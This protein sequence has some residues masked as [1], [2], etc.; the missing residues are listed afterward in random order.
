M[1]KVNLSPILH[2]IFSL[3][4]D[5]EMDLFVSQGAIKRTLW[6]ASRKNVFFCVAVGN[7][8]YFMARY[9]ENRFFRPAG[10]NKM[11]FIT[12]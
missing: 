4:G 11:D 2:T 3:L 7:K 8:M 10:G 5:R 9:W 1:S 6:P 12:R